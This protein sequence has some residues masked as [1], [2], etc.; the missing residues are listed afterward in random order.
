M[1]S[2]QKREMPQ[3]SVHFHT[4]GNMKTNKEEKCIYTLTTMIDLNAESKHYIG[5]KIHGLS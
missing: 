2:L 1:L 5:T 3:G 4:I